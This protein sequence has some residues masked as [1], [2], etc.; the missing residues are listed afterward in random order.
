MKRACSMRNIITGGMLLLCMHVPDLA[1]PH[2]TGYWKYAVQDGGV[3]YLES[4]QT[5]NAIFVGGRAGIS[6]TPYGTLQVDKLHVEIPSPF[7]A[8]DAKRFTP[9]EATATG[10]KF[11]ATCKDQDGGVTSGTLERVPLPELR[12]LI[13]NGLATGA[14]LGQLHAALHCEHRNPLAEWNPPDS[15]ECQKR[16]SD[17]GG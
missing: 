3:N 7:G 2:L 13:D 15:H 10:D 1:Q 5:G 6:Q 14:Y 4:K 8:P 11:P 16:S 17:S 12:D 9:Y